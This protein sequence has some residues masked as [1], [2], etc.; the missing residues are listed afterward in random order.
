MFKSNALELDFKLEEGMEVVASCRCSLYPGLGSMQLYINKLQKEGLG[1]L[2]IKFEK[3]KNKLAKEGYFSEENKK[4]IPIMPKKI[5]IVTSETGAVIRDIINVT[6]RRN[7][8]VDIVLYPALVQGEGA[9][10][11][12]ISG[13]EYFNKNKKWCN[14]YR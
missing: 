11:T 3:L 9:Y 1:E 2:H 12:I 14:N 13:I 10:K 6:R 8:L 7:S 5:G 4:A